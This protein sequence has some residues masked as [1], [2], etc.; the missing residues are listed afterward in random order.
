MTDDAC[1]GALAAAGIATSKPDFETPF[2]AQ[3]LLLDGPV[4]GVAIRPKWRRELR[5]NEVMDCRLVLALRGAARAA[6]A[7]GF[8]E[9]LFYSTYRPIQEPPAECPDGAAGKRCRAARAAWAKAAA[10]KASM[11]RRGL[12]IDIGW[13]TATDGTP[14]EVLA[15]YERHD[16]AP[17]C[18]APAATD[19][20][21]RLR[22]FACALH[23]GKAFNVVLTP[24]ANKAHHNHFH[25][26]VT[27]NA[28]WYI[29]R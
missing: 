20:G 19:L 7:S 10:G 1:A 13:L 8:A 9:I 18:A 15:S 2:V 26:D 6:R 21:K 17:P 24:N 11:H 5:V 28:R 23:A 14:V 27:P 4:E 3:P 22:D 25:F 12:A 16:G 29:V